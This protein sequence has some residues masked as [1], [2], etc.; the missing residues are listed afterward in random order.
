MGR[1]FFWM[2]MFVFLVVVFIAVFIGTMTFWWLAFVFDWVNIPP[3]I[4]VP[5]YPPAP[6]WMGAMGRTRGI[7][8]PIF[9]LLWIVL[10]VFVVT[11]IVRFFQRNVAPLR[12]LIEAVGQVQS[13]DYGTRVAVPRRTSREM[14]ALLNAFNNMTTRLQQNENSRRNLLAD[15]THELRTPLTVI[16]GNIE[17]L[18]DGVYP[19]D[20]AHLT[21]ILEETDVMARLIDD[22]RTLS[23]VESGRLN[24]Q[25]ETTE[26]V[27][28]LQEVVAAFN[29]RAAKQ[30]VALV[31][32]VSDPLPALNLD[33]VRMRE[34]L[35]NLI[36]NALR[37][38]PAGGQIK[39]EARIKPASP[40]QM[41][42]IVVS[43][44]GKGIAEE[45]LPHVFDRF[46]K[47]DDSQGSGLGLAI[48]KQLIE[49]HGGSIR[50]ESH[51]GQGTTMTISFWH[52]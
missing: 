26:L 34:V 2:M 16:R 30:S 24:L 3:I 9:G 38:T 33:P 44:T 19:R 48:A 11:R 52:G 36:V 1:R 15:V 14:R 17:G 22:L 29:V 43:D 5:Q 37:Y 13:G 7:A 10:I 18:I 42:E 28:L 47:G 25:R 46:A 35:S 4:A 40:T 41:V 39:L 51:L 23:L 50:A 12:N 49:A 31:L 21:P 20:E 6:P 32:N 8:G 27:P 45:L